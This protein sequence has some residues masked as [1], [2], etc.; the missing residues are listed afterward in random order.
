MINILPA[1]L[2]R[3]TLVL[4]RLCVF[5]SLLQLV[6]HRIQALLKH[7]R[8]QREAGERERMTITRCQT[9][10]RGRGEEDEE[11]IK[12]RGGKIKRDSTN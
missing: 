10:Y 2:L 6:Q 12:G 4:I 5:F 1:K 8:K 9:I 3:Q 7:S 11:M